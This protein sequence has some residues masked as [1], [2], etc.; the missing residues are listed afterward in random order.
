MTVPEMAEEDDDSWVPALREASPPIF[1]AGSFLV[2]RGGVARSETG[3][4]AFLM[5]TRHQAATPATTISKR[6]ATV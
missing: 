4:V 2:V 3:G 5:M 6:A 1:A